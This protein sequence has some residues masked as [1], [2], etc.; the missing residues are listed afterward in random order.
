MMGWMILASFDVRTTN[1][2]IL[3][4]V[5]D[6]SPPGWSAGMATTI[7][8]QTFTVGITGQLTQI[9][10]RLGGWSQSAVAFSI[11]PTDDDKL[12]YA[13]AP[14]LASGS[15]TFS[16]NADGDGWVQIDLIF[17]NLMVSSGDV[18]A[19]FSTL[20]TNSANW[21]G[22]SAPGYTGGHAY[23]NNPDFHPTQ[24]F[25]QSFDLQFRSYI[26]IVP[27]PSSLIAFALPAIG[28]LRRIRPQRVGTYC[29]ASP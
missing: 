27:E 10:L 21:R 18:L 16:P 25:A 9:D 26:A 6:H 20:P 14:I 28:L 2:A 24:F 8:V 17:E 5:H 7:Q 12:P 13:P 23:V 19:I 22:H 11:R 1:A 3:D 4:Q 15:G 29:V